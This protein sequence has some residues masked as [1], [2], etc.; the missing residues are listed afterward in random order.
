MSDTVLIVLIVA[1]AVVVVLYVFRSRLSRFSIRAN[2]AGL[3]AELQTRDSSSAGGSAGG[4]SGK[5]ACVNISR[6]LQAGKGNVIEVGRSN[7]NVSD[8]KQLGEENVI[9]AQTEEPKKKK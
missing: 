3:D 9:R 1:V 2:Q 8:N 7:A 4:S 6:N 5:S